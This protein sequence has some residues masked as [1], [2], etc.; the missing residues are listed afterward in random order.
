[1]RL[2]TTATRNATPSATADQLSNLSNGRR[3]PLD[4]LTG[5]IP[6]PH[7]PSPTIADLAG[8]PD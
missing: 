5:A 4:N 6:Q 8:P 1:V 2:W 3:M 7:L